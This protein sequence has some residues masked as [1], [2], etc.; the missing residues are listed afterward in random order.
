MHLPESLSEPGGGEN[1]LTT[2]RKLRKLDHTIINECGALSETAPVSNLP[3]EILC[4]IFEASQD[5][6]IGRAHV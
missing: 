5:A 1:T 6:Q 3:I 2:K 4:Q